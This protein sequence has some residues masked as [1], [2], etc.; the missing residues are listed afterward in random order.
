MTANEK[1]L[2]A[3]LAIS[4]TIIL[5]NIF[6]VASGSAEVYYKQIENILSHLFPTL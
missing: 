2:V 3:A 1:H 5:F 4:T 6:A